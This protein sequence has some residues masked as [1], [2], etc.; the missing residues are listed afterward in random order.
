MD[1]TPNHFAY[2]TDLHIHP[3]PEGIDPQQVR[4]AIT[5]IAQE[6]GFHLAILDGSTIHDKSGLLTAMAYAYTF[7]RDIVPNL[8]RLNWDGVTDFM[9][10][11]SW[12]ID[13]PHQATN[14]AGFILLYL[15]PSV[16]FMTAPVDFATFL[17]IIDDASEVHRREGLLFHLV[18]GPLDD[19]ALRLLELLKV[20][21]H[22]CWSHQIIPS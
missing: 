19:T 4:F 11:L 10:D 22:V 17:S 1:I 3:F 8:E 2:P 21:D 15:D 12:L 16:L 9:R 18:L 13:R 14:F 5:K 7:P 20:A 6:L